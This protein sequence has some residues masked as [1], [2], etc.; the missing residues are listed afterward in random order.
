MLPELRSIAGFRGMTVSRRDADQEVLHLVETRWDSLAAIRAFAGDEL[1]RA[2]VPAAAQTLL[3][4]FDDVVEHFHVV[5][6]E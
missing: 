2:V 4:S 5:L 3:S 6:H 1:D